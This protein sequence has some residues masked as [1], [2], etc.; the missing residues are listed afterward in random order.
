MRLPFALFVPLATFA[1][2]TALAAPV[3]PTLAPL[4]NAPTFSQELAT[5]Y[6]AFSSPFAESAPEATEAFRAKGAAA[7]A[8]APVPPIDPS[9]TGSDD[10][11]AVADLAVGHAALLQVLNGGAAVYMPLSA[12]NAQ[13]KYDCW[14]TAVEADAMAAGA[15]CRTFFFNEMGRI[16]DQL[17][18]R[19]DSRMKG[20]VLF[21][22]GSDRLNEWADPVID[23]IFE[24][25]AAGRPEAVV[26]VGRTDTVG[27][28]Q[29]NVALSERRALTVERA[30]EARGLAPDLVR[31]ELLPLG[32]DSPVVET[33]DEVPLVFNR[34]VAVWAGTEAD[35]E[36]ALGAR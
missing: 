32:Q 11:D 17:G 22:F 24:V 1:V 15:T 26:V 30:L 14:A 10:A 35:V 34:Q 7:G 16:R 33:G 4:R 27:S 18:L 20:V 29:T 21:D 36:A 23:T 6:G 31:Y 8:G 9:A 28:T 2:Q 25:I 13:V 19:D 5:A 12:A 3:D